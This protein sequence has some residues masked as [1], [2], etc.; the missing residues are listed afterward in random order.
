MAPSSSASTTKP[1][2]TYDVFI[3]FRGKDTRGNFVSHLYAALSNAGINTFLDNEE[4]RKGEELEPE[5]LRAIHG[6]RIAIVVFSENYVRSSW[7]LN[8]LI[9]IMECRENMKQVVMPVFYNITPSDI[10]QYARQTFG[11][12]FKMVTNKLDKLKCVALGSASYLAG[13]D[14]SNYR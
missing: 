1:Q 7:C 9:Q 6:S 11:E 14:M 4:L 13:W 12:P 10:R 5:L 3:N 8:E 2:W